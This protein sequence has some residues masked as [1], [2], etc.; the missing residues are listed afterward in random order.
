MR[1]SEGER[2]DGRLLVDI[3]DQCGEELESDGSSM[4]F[5][6]RIQ[7]QVVYGACV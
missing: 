4:I 2:Y 1:L 5:W 3:G 6:V 7:R